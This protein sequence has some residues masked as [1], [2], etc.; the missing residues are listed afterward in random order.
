MFSN[1]VEIRN[2]DSHSIVD[3]HTKKRINSASSVEI[4]DHVWL[5]A[6]VR[7]LKGSVIPSNSIVANS[8]VVTSKFYTK[9]YICWDAL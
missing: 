6:H 3:M 7:V 4:N 9:C 5:T 2:G 8:G 1:D